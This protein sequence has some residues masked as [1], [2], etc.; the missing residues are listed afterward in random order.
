MCLHENDAAALQAGEF[1]IAMIVTANPRRFSCQHHTPLKMWRTLNHCTPCC[2]FC[3]TL[4]IGSADPYS[5]V[6]AWQAPQSHMCTKAHL[7][8]LLA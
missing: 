2:C 7:S 3:L 6:V 8:A 5:S 1:V 4:I